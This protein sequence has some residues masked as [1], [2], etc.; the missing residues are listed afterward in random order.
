[1][2][3]LF[4]I[5][6]LSGQ[7]FTFNTDALGEGLFSDRKVQWGIYDVATCHDSIFFERYGRDIRD[8][9]IPI[10]GRLFTYAVKD[11]TLLGFE[12]LAI[13]YPEQNLMSFQSEFQFIDH[14][15]LTALSCHTD[16]L[17]Y[18]AGK[19]ITSY[20]WASETCNYLGNLP[21]AMQAAGD[22]TSRQG[23]LYLST[24]SNT[25]VEVDIRNPMNSQVVMTFPVGTPPI[26]AMTTLQGECNDVVTYAIG[27][28]STG[29]IIYELDFENKTLIERCRTPRRIMGAASQ[30]ECVIPICKVYVDLDKNNSSGGSRYD[31]HTPS[32]CNASV[33]IADQDLE[34]YAEE[35]IDSVVITLN[36]ILDAGLENLTATATTN[37]SVN[38]SGT[39]KITIVNI[40]NATI[41]DFRRAIARIF[42]KNN[43]AAPAN[44]NREVWVRGYTRSY[45]GEIATARIQ[46][47]NNLGLEQDSI[48]LKC[49]GDT[50]IAF[51]AK[52]NGGVAPYRYQWASGD[53]TAVRA[54]LATGTYPIIIS[55][56]SGCQLIDTVK[57][58]QPDRFTVRISALNDSICGASGKLTAT[59]AGGT[60]PYSYQWNHNSSA[61]SNTNSLENL[62]AGTYILSVTDQNGCQTVGSYTLTQVDTVRTWEEIKRC[63]DEI[64]DWQ[65]QQIKND[66]SFCISLISINGCDSLHCLEVQFL[67]TTLIQESIMLCNQETYNGL[68]ISRDTIICN[69]FIGANGCDSTYCLTINVLKRINQL[70]AGICEGESY[71]FAGKTLTTAG[72]YLDTIQTGGNCDSLISLNLQ[73]NPKPIVQLTK[74]GS[75]C[76]GGTLK[77]EATEGFRS[78]TWST[79]ATT[80]FINVTAP[81]KYHLTVTN[82]AGCTDTTSIQIAN[83][84]FEPIINA[85]DPTCFGKKDGSIVIDTV[86]GGNPPYFYRLDNRTAQTTNQFHQLTGGTYQVEVEDNNG[87][88]T[89]TAVTLTEPAPLTLFIGDDTTLALGDSLTLN[90]QTNVVDPMVQWNPPTGLSCATCLTT[91]AKPVE[92]IR[93]EVILTDQ[94]G[95]VAKDAISI[96]VDRQSNTF[97]PNAFSPNGDGVNDMFTVFADGS[98]QR[99][100]Y[101]RVFDRWGNML[102]ELK[103]FVPGTT[104]KG[105]DGRFK[106]KML[107][108]GAYVYVLEVER[109]DGVIEKLQGEVL[110]V[111]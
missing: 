18:G 90:V 30:Q 37:L 14:K 93:Y 81:G 38:G 106:G 12:G 7:R 5:G 33:Y 100:V 31:F 23:K 109:I 77:V 55:D 34:V 54:N 84:S 17:I 92:S 35:A 104:E 8:I 27:T 99:I 68:A 111:R 98:V 26:H 70:T 73:V 50:G 40:G 108:E 11:S 20:N 44:G 22:L 4:G 85:F 52:A 88:F 110:L 83:E 41:E 86:M 1:M 48:S 53:T 71:L 59:P 102:Y 62:E 69:T 51:T 87:C 82:A 76:E 89:K 58:T 16:G 67:D 78:Y 66:T 101:L 10:D 36:G 80:P 105:W 79:G 28:D 49:Y 24:I 94:S 21:P 45:T 75:L 91:I 19:G 60:I 2:M 65:G 6:E 95:C 47:Q 9:A 25:L 63:A 32:V 64:F 29:S 3:H 72:T 57:V 56:Q 103:D 42:Y 15:Y 39:D 43:S 107:P 74:N 96:L 97:I 46:I 61:P 13:F